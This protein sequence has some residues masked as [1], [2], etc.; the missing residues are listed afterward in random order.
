MF[1]RAYGTRTSKLHYFICSALGFLLSLKDMKIREITSAIETLAP[2]RLQEE[3]DNAGLQVGFEQNEVTGVLVCLD[4][5]EEVVTEAIGNGCNLVVSHHPLIFKPLSCV[6]D[7]TWQQKTVV[8]A[9][10]NGITLYSAHTNLDNARG[11]VNFHIANILGLKNVEW[12]EAKPGIDAGSGIIGQLPEAVDSK[13]FLLR[14]KELFG[15][16]A[17][18]HSQIRKEKIET[19]AVCGGSGAFLREAARQ[20]R[21]DCFVTGEIHYHDWFEAGDL[22]MAELGHYESEQF[23][24]DL[25][26]GYLHTAFPEL[27]IEKLS[28]STNPIEVL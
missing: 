18:R 26:A 5:T 16:R 10:K 1:A 9:L 6:S 25:L 8:D 15:V 14:L 13:E 4:I 7:R 2:L 23:T 11:G 21:A 19:I 3:Y 17:L 22:L 20:K 12:L 28:F 24:I 27:K